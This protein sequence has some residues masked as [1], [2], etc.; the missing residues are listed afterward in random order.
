MCKSIIRG[1]KFEVTDTPHKFATSHLL[2]LSDILSQKSQT[3]KTFLSICCS[4]D[5]PVNQA[6]TALA[7]METDGVI[8]S[9]NYSQMINK[10]SITIALP[11]SVQQQVEEFNILSHVIV[12]T[13]ANE[14]KVKVKMFT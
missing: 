8:D 13:Q 10:P 5:L 9:N 2:E 4:L 14:I 12:G 6:Y 3:M 1:L 11:T 7:K